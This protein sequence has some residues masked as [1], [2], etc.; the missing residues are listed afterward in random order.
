[1]HTTSATVTVTV[2]NN[3]PPP[4]PPP[5]PPASGARFEETDPS[6]TFT[7]NG[8]W[9]QDTSRPWSGGGAAFSTTP[10]AQAT[11]T[12]TGTSVTWIGGRG[13]GNGHTRGS[14]GGGFLRK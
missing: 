8:G 7:P 10:G 4:P 6:V 12:F 14:P 1:N 2:A 3:A 9:T 13:A 5:P 11:F